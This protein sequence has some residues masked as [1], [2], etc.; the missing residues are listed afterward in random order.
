MTRLRPDLAYARIVMSHNNS[1]VSERDSR[2][3][4]SA[5]R[6]ANVNRVRGLGAASTGKRRPF[7]DCGLEIFDTFASI[8]GPARLPNS[9]HGRET[10]DDWCASLYAYGAIR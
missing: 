7:G 8:F 6:F 1:G 3:G 10:T 4:V 5:S 2:D 9:E